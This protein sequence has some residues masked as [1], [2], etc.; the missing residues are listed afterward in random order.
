MIEVKM[1]NLRNYYNLLRIDRS[2]TE[3]DI[4]KAYR[5]LA[6]EFHPDVNTD[7]DAEDKF[8]EIGEAYAVLSDTQKRQIYDQT[9]TTDF[10]GPGSMSNRPSPGR[11]M[12]RCRGMGKCSGLDALFRRRPRYAKKMNSQE[13]IK[14]ERNQSLP[15]CHK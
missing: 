14:D 7:K 5:K 11:G 4:K 10:T 3:S 2:A 15:H 1:M 8:K 13:T 12:G 9:G 6:I